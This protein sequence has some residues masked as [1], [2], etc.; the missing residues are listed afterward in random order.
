M[1]VELVLTERRADLTEAR[2]GNYEPVLATWYGPGFFGH[3]T[4]CGTVLTHATL[5]VAHKRLPCGTKVALRY[6]GQDGW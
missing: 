4:A 1:S 3:R 5:G 2:A 6:R